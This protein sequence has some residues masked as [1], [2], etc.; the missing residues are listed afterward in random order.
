M[1]NTRPKRARRAPEAARA[2]LVEA[3]RA[4]MVKGRGDFEIADVARRANV[5]VGL[6][7]HYF[8]SKSGLI[9]AVVEDFYDRLDEAIAAEFPDGLD[10]VERERART[11][12][13]VH[14]LV[15]DPMAPYAFGALVGMPEVAAIATRR[16]DRIIDEGARNLAQ[17]QS[18][19]AVRADLDPDV[20]SAALHGAIRQVLLR[21]FARS[22][23]PGRDRLQTCI[24]TLV[25]SWVIPTTR[26]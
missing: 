1:A 13:F 23:R 10:W 9:A 17:G 2:L 5:S 6:P 8:G 12:R 3:A 26:R 25:E 22:K 21:E 14:A 4:E 18:Q 19:G 15:D 24:W 16:L 11:R 20:L 7:Y